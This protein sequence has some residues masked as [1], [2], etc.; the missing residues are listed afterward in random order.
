[1]TATTDTDMP[2]QL[3]EWGMESAL[4]NLIPKGAIRDLRRFALDDKEEMGRNRIATMKEIAAV[5]DE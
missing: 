1:M 3:A 2:E 5:L 4:W